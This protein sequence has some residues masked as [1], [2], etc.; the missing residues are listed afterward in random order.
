MGCNSI[1]FDRSIGIG[2]PEWQK[3]HTDDNRR[4]DR[5]VWWDFKDLKWDVEFSKI[6]SI[7]GVDVALPGILTSF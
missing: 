4:R 3:P 2:H 6:A 5:N 7:F 1:I